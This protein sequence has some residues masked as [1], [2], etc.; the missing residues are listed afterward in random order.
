MTAGSVLL[1]AGQEEEGKEKGLFRALQPIKSGGWEDILELPKRQAAEGQTTFH[2]YCV[3]YLTT[4]KVQGPP[5]L[6]PTISSVLFPDGGRL[7]SQSAQQLPSITF[8]IYM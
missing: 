7:H 6:L 4:A 1:L 3:S 5:G 2:Q 8:V